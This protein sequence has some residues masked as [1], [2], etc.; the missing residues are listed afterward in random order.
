M[1]ALHTTNR[2]PHPA[3]LLLRPWEEA[4]VVIVG[5]GGNGSWVVPHAARL[6]RVLQAKGKKLRIMLI[7]PD[8]VEEKNI[9][10]QNFCDADLA[11]KP[12]LSKASS[13]AF[14]YG[15]AL[16]IEVSAICEKFDPYMLEG[17]PSWPYRRDHTT[18]RLTIIVSCV[19]NAEARKAVFKVL[20]ANRSYEAPSFWVLD[21]GNFPAN[22]GDECGQVYLGSA[23]TPEDL[24]FSFGITNRCLALP[25]PALQAPDLLIA[26][27]EE[28]AQSP[29]SCAEITRA[30]E[31]GLM[32]N[33]MIASWVGYYLFA[34]LV[35][36][37]LRLMGTTVNLTSGKVD[38]DYIT[39]ENVAR[40]IGKEVS[41]FKKKR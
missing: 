4:V 6:A 9:Y 18:E 2:F 33:P 17:V 40:I 5:V 10:R 26:R 34:M 36:G 31:Q 22:V 7:D 21:C 28:L 41:F 16:G 39:K 20:E 27:P 11:Q 30:N 35:T 15:L 32:I 1:S 29:L 19:D 12:P 14:R 3:T 24:E 23:A 13:L 25:S 8:S 38:S 37:D